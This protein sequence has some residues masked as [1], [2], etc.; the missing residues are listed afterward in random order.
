[1]RHLLLL[2]LSL[3]CIA[4][5]DPIDQCLY[6]FELNDSAADGWDGN[7]FEIW[8]D[9]LVVTLGPQLQPGMASVSVP[10][11]LCM[12]E[13]YYIVRSN[14]SS[15]HEQ[16]SLSLENGLGV[17]V[18]QYP[19]MQVDHEPQYF[20]T[21]VCT[22]DDCQPPVDLQVFTHG[23]GPKLHW[24]VGGDSPWEVIVLPQGSAAPGDD[25]VGM[26]SNCPFD[27][28]DYQDQPYDIYVRTLCTWGGTSAWESL[29]G[30]N[31]IL[32]I[33]TTQPV[34]FTIYPVPADDLLTIASTD[35]IWHGTI[36]DATGRKVLNISGDG[37]VT[38]NVSN[39][40]MGIYFL[41]ARSASG[42]VSTKKF[43]VR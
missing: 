8:Q 35:G 2:F 26:I 21:A 14:Q 20:G 25:A 5:C 42:E 29:P 4:Q 16:I 37:D 9:G 19:L 32:G 15:T 11:A 12:G 33:G 23:G 31:T 34:D 24:T 38:V 22:A 18:Y 6:T 27:L 36:T 7:T 41:T 10:V 39:L 1:M 40:K 3:Q 17:T 43:I 30:Y 28:A 13:P